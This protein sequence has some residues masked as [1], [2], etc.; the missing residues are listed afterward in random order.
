MSDGKLGQQPD[1]PI[2]PLLAGAIHLHELKTAYTKAGFT[3]DQAMSL[4]QVILN[5]M[6][7]RGPVE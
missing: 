1:D 4:C 7:M 3:E 6:V 5:A 2:G